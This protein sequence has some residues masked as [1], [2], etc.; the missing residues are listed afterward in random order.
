MARK[1]YLESELVFSEHPK[2]P[3]FQDL[4]GV[5]FGRLTVLGFKGQ[6]KDG[7]KVWFCICACKN[8]IAAKGGNLKSGNTTSCSCANIEI[9]KSISTK[10]G[11]SKKGQWTAEY[12]SWASMLARTQNKNCKEYTYYGGR[13]ITVCDRWQ[14]FEN[15]FADMGEKPGKKY[16]LDRIDNNGNYCPENCRWATMKEQC[17][18][19][20]SNRL[21]TH[22]GKTKNIGQWGLEYGI[23]PYVISGR[24]KRGWSIDKSLTT[25]LIEPTK[26]RNKS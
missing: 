18:N 13:G 23:S 21:I 25:P 14:K 5:V 26:N 22:N 10:H 6:T 2:N 24:I 16:S 3:R 11:Q 15:F 12:C 1:F 20:R 17:D 19:R 7:Y 9:V 4:T 8:I